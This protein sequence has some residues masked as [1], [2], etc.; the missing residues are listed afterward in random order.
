M[1]QV[2]LILAD[3][4]DPA[5][6]NVALRDWDAR[7]KKPEFLHHCYDDAVH[8]TRPAHLRAVVDTRPATTDMRTGNALLLAEFYE[9][10]E[11]AEQSGQAALPGMAS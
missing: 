7:G 8:A 10:Q 9:A 11:R 6:I 4:G 3:N 5:L 1:K 2:D